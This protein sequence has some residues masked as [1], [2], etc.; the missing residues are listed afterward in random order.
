LKDE[1]QS[2]YEELG[3]HA[4]LADLV[5][6]ARSVAQSMVLRRTIAWPGAGVRPQA[7]EAKLRPEEATTPFGDALAVLERGPE[8]DSERALV[9][10][11]WAHAIAETP[12]KGREAED[13]L[14][15]DIAWLA[16]HTPF[17][18][19]RLIDR[20][21]GDAAA[22]VWDALAARVRKIDAQKIPAS[23]GEGLVAC[24]ALAYSTS[25]AAAK[26]ASAMSKELKDPFFKRVLAGTGSITLEARIEGELAPAPR[27]PLAT[28]ALALSGLLFL[29][30][31]ARALG[32]LALA[33]RH[34]AEVTLSAES[35]RIR[36]RTELLGRTL[37]DRNVVIGRQGLVRAAREV[38]YPGAAFYAGLLAL[39][40][41]S[42]F[43]VAMLV[44]GTRAASPSLLLAG[45]A[46][47]AGGIALDFAFTSL[48]PGMRGRCRVVFVPRKGPAIC[49]GNVD[50]DRADD[51]LARL[52]AK[53]EHASPA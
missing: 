40:V 1:Q 23:R 25:A 17:D 49:V 11:L 28:A 48:A 5:A 20:A 9:A 44:D 46:V 24:A 15:A 32:R 51:A 37:R 12:P 18:V 39:A 50:A 42:Y 7:A 16:S 26:H 52:T 53:A 33:Y 36:S 30:N 29:T 14:A 41:G 43:G 47:V 6:L 38:R 27:G 10:A 4:R 8:T 2:A 31:G 19:T 21:L 3:K 13:R 45:L 35:I 22:D 34:P